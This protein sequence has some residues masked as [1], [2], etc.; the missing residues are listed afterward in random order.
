[1]ADDRQYLNLKLKAQLELAGFETRYHYGVNMSSDE[2]GLLARALNS[3]DKQIEARACV[4]YAE[5][6][7]NDGCRCHF[8]FRS[9]LIAIDS[10]QTC[11]R[12]TLTR[13]RSL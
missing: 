10:A 6:A 1:M 5:K 7:I 3:S 11:K 8:E 2:D 4:I 9:A 12:L 13:T